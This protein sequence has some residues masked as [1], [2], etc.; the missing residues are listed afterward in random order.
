MP[1]AG[2]PGTM[3]HEITAGRNRRACGE[4][5][6]SEVLLVV[7]QSPSLQAHRLAALVVYFDPVVEQPIFVREE[8]IV[9]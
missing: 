6:L 2:E 9:P 5:P 4:D 3:K 1:W 7:G 8:R